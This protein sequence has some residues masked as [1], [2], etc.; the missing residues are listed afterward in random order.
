MPHCISPEVKE[1]HG[2][3]HG[4]ARSVTL[5]S[6]PSLLTRSGF[7][8]PPL[9]VLH[10]LVLHKTLSQHAASILGSVF[11]FLNKLLGTITRVCERIITSQL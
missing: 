1:W 9:R 3:G 5:R 11:F 7:L 2:A 6:Y 8:S 4:A 10:S